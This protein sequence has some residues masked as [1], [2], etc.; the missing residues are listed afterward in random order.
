[1]TKL[2]DFQTWKAFPAEMRT[3]ERI[4]LAYAYDRQKRKF[5]ELLRT[6]YIWADLDQVDDEKLDFLAVESRVMFYNSLLEANIKRNLIRNHLGWHMKLGTKQAMEEV[7]STYY[8]DSE[9]RMEEW[10]EYEGEPYHFRITTTASIE[11]DCYEELRQLIK[12]VKNARS[13]LDQIRTLRE[14]S[15]DTYVTASV[16]LTYRNHPLQEDMYITSKAGREIKIA[17]GIAAV[18]RQSIR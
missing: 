18:Q 5:L 13:R 11:E 8:P 6:V 15:G 12:L 17:A 9:T 3:P 4:A 7:V 2:V 14:C 1:M 10:F 16:S